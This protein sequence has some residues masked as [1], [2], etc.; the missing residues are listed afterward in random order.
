MSASSLYSRSL[1]PHNTQPS[2]PGRIVGVSKTHA[3]KARLD[4][5]RAKYDTKYGHTTGTTLWSLQCPM[6]HYE[7]CPYGGLLLLL[8]SPFTIATLACQ[9]WHVH[10]PRSRPI[11]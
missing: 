5:K 11:L 10:D 9:S 6:K 8:A 7:A 3:Y 2:V 1:D 4:A